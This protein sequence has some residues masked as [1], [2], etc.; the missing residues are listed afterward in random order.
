MFADRPLNGGTCDKKEK[1]P[2]GVN[3]KSEIM[4]RRRRDSHRPLNGGIC[5]GKE[6][7]P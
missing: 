1:T 5:D 6:K 3:R 2:R 4:L 7:T